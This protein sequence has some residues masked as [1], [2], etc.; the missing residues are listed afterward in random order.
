MCRSVLPLFIIPVHLLVFLG[1]GFCLGSVLLFDFLS[2]NTHTHTQRLPEAFAPFLLG[3][4]RLFWDS[5]ADSDGF[6]LV[7]FFLL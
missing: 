4:L 7:L 2:R 5:D 1:P 3:M 6:G